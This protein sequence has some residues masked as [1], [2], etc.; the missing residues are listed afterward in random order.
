MVYM[1]L[2]HGF[3]ETEAL[4][5][6]DLLRRA[7]VETALAAVND[8]LARGGHDIRV[9]CDCSLAEVDLDAAEMLVL[10]GGGVGVEN[11]SRSEQTRA[12]VCDAARR[13]IPV[14]AI[15][16]A[17]TLLGGWGLLEG[18]HA[19]CYPG[20]EAGMTGAVTCPEQSVV[21][22]GNFITARAAGSA[23]DFGL[24]LI[25]RLKGEDKAEEVKHG[26]HYRG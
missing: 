8:R 9:E 22:D 19:V 24:A 21:E 14:A 13:G 17:P 10:P 18:V 25:R 2:A 3:E 23:F 4:V 5:T 1:L 15:C 26:V 11:L 20:W 6:A 16:A 12:L 7:G